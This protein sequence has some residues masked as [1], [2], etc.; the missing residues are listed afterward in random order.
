[1]PG[2]PSTVKDNAL[3]SMA[4]IIIRQKTRIQEANRIDIEAARKSGLSDAM[5]DRLTL[6]DTRIEGYGNR[7]FAKSLLSPI[8]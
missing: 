2:L 8:R 7:N 1:M 5:I 6:T 4:D 3:R